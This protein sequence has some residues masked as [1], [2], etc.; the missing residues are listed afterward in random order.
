MQH[1]FLDPAGT[2]PYGK[3]AYVQ[4][5]R[6]C[7][8][9]DNNAHSVEIASTKMTG[10]G[11]K[12]REIRY[13]RYEWFSWHAGTRSSANNTVT[14]ASAALIGSR[15]TVGHAHV[16]LHHTHWRLRP[17]ELCFFFHPTIDFR[18]DTLFQSVEFTHLQHSGI[19]IRILT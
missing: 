1:F 5:T 18:N 6:R 12:R 15:H 19:T 13:L 11:S 3:T 2:T 16:H 7:P 8:C 17:L 4:P 10:R 14:K 9:Y